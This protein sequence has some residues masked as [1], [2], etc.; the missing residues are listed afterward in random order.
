MKE[1]EN[2]RERERERA[3]GRD[4]IFNTETFYRSHCSQVDLSCLPDKSAGK[5][6]VVRACSRYCVWALCEA[7][8][9]QRAV[10]VPTAGTYEL[11]PAVKNCISCV[12]RCLLH[13][14]QLRPELST[15]SLTSCVP[16]LVRNCISCV[17]SCQPKA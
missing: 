7:G 5:W 11:R 12:P 16:R 14:Y 3:R 15:P 8:S 1:K 13:V 10:W 9:M 6:N 17:P 2:S 4:Y